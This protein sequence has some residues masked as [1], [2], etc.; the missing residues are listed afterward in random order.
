MI[1]HNASTTKSYICTFQEYL[2]SQRSQESGTLENFLASFPLTGSKKI[3]NS[4]T[5]IPKPLVELKIMF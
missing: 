3:I 1:T 5:T 4:N 2:V